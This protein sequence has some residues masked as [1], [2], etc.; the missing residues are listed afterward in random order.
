LYFNFLFVNIHIC[1]DDGT[2]W[3]ELDIR[4]RQ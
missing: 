2:D 1:I 4:I 3:D